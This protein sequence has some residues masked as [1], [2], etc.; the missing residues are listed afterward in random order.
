MYWLKDRWKERQRLIL[1]DG[2]VFLLPRYCVSR[3][4]NTK[5]VKSTRIIMT[6]LGVSRGEVLSAAE[7]VIT[8]RWSV[9]SIL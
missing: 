1:N 2:G 9:S 6:A 8:S 5:H 3:E 4:L 7:P